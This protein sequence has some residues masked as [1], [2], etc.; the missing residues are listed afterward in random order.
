MSSDFFFFCI[1]FGVPVNGLVMFVVEEFIKSPSEIS[2]A[3]CTKDQ[4]VEIATYYSIAVSNDDKRLKSSLFKL[5][6]EG[7]LDKEII[8]LS[9]GLVVS[10]TFGESSDSEFK[11][12]ETSVTAVSQ[13]RTLKTNA[14]DGAYEIKKL[15]LQHEL[16]MR[17]L[18]Y[19]CEREQREFQSR[20]K[21]R[22]YQ[23]EQA[24]HDFEL[25][26]FAIELEV[27]KLHISQSV[28]AVLPGFSSQPVSPVR[29]SAVNFGD[30]HPTSVQHS[31]SAPFM[32]APSAPVRTVPLISTDSA[33]LYIPAMTPLP[34]PNRSTAPVAPPLIDP[35]VEI[36]RL[37]RMVPPFN[38]DEVDKYFAHFERVALTLKW[39]V[40]IW[41]LLLQ[42]VLRGKA[43]SVYSAL[44]I[45]QGTDYQTVKNAILTAY[46]LVP[47]AYRQKFRSLRKSDG[48][49]FVEFARERVR[50]IGGARQSMLTI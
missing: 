34:I 49:T 26:R 28:P 42:T 5:V 33:G 41:T 20:E 16:E 29:L 24:Q 2:L 19:Q 35:P 27:K 10:P 32:D 1:F 47:E 48:I 3:R 12:E 11:D 44:T 15:E 9:E 14:S 40:E 18:E 21:D 23:R 50:L 17:K 36:S 37:V 25:K 6:R 31:E 39:P 43:Q 8:S 22:E 13:S 38:E 30:A 46:E 4:L 45:E 7:L